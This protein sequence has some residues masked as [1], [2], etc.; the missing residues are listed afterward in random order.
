MVVDLD[1]HLL[2]GN[3]TSTFATPAQ[4]EFS[5]KYAG[6]NQRYIQH[7]HQYLT[8]HHFDSHLAYLQETWD[9]TLAEQLGRDFQRTSSSAAKSVHC[10]PH[11][12]YVTKLAK[13]R[14]EKNVLKQVSSQHHTGI[15]LSS[16]IVHPVRDGNDF[17]LPATIP[18][19]QQQCRDAQ[20]EIHKLEKVLKHP[21]SASAL[22]WGL[23]RCNRLHRSRL[24]R[25]QIISS[26]SQRHR[27]QGL[28]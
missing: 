27:P 16:S 4:R 15:D 1:M 24:R 18:E 28:T 8:Q 2:F 21:G 3:P 14:K 26:M 23:R 22:P 20:Q 5:S 10:K 7:K 13:L 19:Y 25:D 11:G 17:L 6:S 12:P 9:P